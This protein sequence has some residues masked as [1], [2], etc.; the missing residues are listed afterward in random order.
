MVNAQSTLKRILILQI[1]LAL[2]LTF[3]EISARAEIAVQSSEKSQKNDWMEENLLSAKENPAFSFIYDGKNSSELLPAWSRTEKRRSLDNHRVEH[4]ITWT[5]SATKLSVRC[6]GVDYNDF[7]VVEWTV[8]FSNN[9]SK[10]TPILEN[11]QAL[12][13]T[14]KRAKGSEFLL[15]GNQGDYCVAQSF[16][17]FQVKLMPSVATN[18]SPFAYSG[19]SCDGPA[20]WPYYNLQT[21]DGGIMLAIGWPAQWASSFTRDAGDGLRIKAGQQLP[22]LVLKP[23][24]EIR[25]PL[26]AM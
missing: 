6:V 26:I 3:N 1:F 13:T 4:T 21:A 2:L 18:F 20:G 8:Y 10:P 7:P 19:K 11:I 14:L 9:G 25:T 12:D 16:E 22:H 23:G 17:P 15:N 5:D 24:E